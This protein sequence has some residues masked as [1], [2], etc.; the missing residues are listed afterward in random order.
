[1]TKL[2]GKVREPLTVALATNDDA[3]HVLLGRKW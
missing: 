1:M 3:L 2:V